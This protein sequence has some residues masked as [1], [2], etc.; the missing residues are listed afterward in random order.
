[1]KQLK[2]SFI[3]LLAL[4][5]GIGFSAFT[6]KENKQAK[7]FEADYYW[8]ELSTSNPGKVGVRVDPSLHNITEAMESLTDCENLTE[9]LCLVGSPN[10]N[11]VA[12]VSD[13]PAESPE[14]DNY[15][16]KTE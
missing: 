3:C 2:I 11:L 1:M 9:E 4:A 8:Y 14:E 10:P 5:L 16:F 6:G 12:N 15:I 7:T 13:I